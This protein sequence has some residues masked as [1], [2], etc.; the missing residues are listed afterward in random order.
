MERCQGWIGARRQVGQGHPFRDPGQYIGHMFKALTQLSRRLSGTCQVCGRWPTQPLCPVCTQRFA[1][2]QPRC[3]G[4]AAR[5]DHEHRGL[6]GTCQTRTT[7]SALQHCVAAVDYEY[8][9][10][11][12]IARF[13]FRGEPGWSGPMAELMLGVPQTVAL[14]EQCHVMVPVPLTPARL[15]SRGYNQAWELVKDLRRQSA[16]AGSVPPPGLA[17]ALLRIGDA[18]DQ[19]SLPR[20]Q[21]MRNLQGVFIVHP[22][23]RLSQSRVLLVDDVTTTGSTLQ[24]AAQALLQG[25][26]AAVTALVF[27]RTPPH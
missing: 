21:R 6:C 8:P 22:S 9:W 23:A 15:A 25:G 14:M 18:P 7:P 19:H 24:A 12:V 20:E 1:P 10:D 2:L 4:C 26:A 27:A 17:D 16:A 3:T 13:K 5:L 11:S